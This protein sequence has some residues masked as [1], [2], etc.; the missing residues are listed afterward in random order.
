MQAYLRR[1][2]EINPQVNAIVARQPT[3]VLLAQADQC[4]SELAT[5]TT[6]NSHG[7]QQHGHSRGPLH[8]VPI[9]IK[10]LAAVR[11]MVTTSGS[12]LLRD[13]IPQ[14]DAAFVARIRNAGA[15]I[16]GHT[17]TPEFGLGSHTYNA[18]YGR[19]RNAF[20]HSLSSGGSSGGA[21]VALQL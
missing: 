9:A 17:N 3:D 6:T 10:D 21:A 14:E 20:D 8:G 12:L 11:G 13:Y 16:I 1:I 19:T 7:Q 2:D 15:I 5:G 4:D 18:V